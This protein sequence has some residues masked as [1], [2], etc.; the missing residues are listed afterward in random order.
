MLLYD[1]VSET[2]VWKYWKTLFPEVKRE[3]ELRTMLNVCRPFNEK[4]ITKFWNE[5]KVSHQDFIDWLSK[6]EESITSSTKWDKFKDDNHMN[7]M[8]YPLLLFNKD[9]IKWLIEIVKNSQVFCDIDSIL[10]SIVEEI[11]LRLREISIRTFITEINVE[12]T[13]NRLRGNDKEKRY[14]DYTDRRWRSKSYV[15]KF[16][17]EYQ[18]LLDMQLEVFNHTI[19]AIVEMIERIQ[20]NYSELMKK[21]FKGERNVLIEEIQPGL[22]DSHRGGRTVASITF[23]N[24]KKLIYKPRNLGAE[25]G[26]SRYSKAMNEGMSLKEKALYEI[27]LLDCGEYG[28]IEF[29]SQKECQDEQ[30][31]ERYYY[32]SGVLMAMLYSL[33]AKDIHHENLIAHGEYPVMIDLEALFHCKLEHKDIENEKTAY[34]VAIDSIDDSVYSITKPRKY[35]TVCTWKQYLLLSW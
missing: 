24:G 8:F 11:C 7:N 33:N 23:T 19:F 34:E 12:K 29:I 6:Q 14:I 21:F 28:F 31:L 25:I 35:E 5:L 16:Y 32:R 26:F 17:T 13:E 2:D 10:E 30:Q 4:E 3:D 27:E 22:G 1:N 20:V 15:E 18:E 9:K